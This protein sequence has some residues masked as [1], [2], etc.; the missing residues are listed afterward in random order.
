MAELRNHLTEDLNL[1]ADLAKSLLAKGTP[2]TCKE[3]ANVLQPGQ[4]NDRVFFL[5]EGIV[6]EYEET[7]TTIWFLGERNWFYN[8]ES[9]ANGTAS[10]AYLQALTV[11]KGISF[12]KKDIDDLVAE[13]PALEKFEKELYQKYLFR[14]NRL[15]RLMRV[16]KAM[17]RWELFEKQQPELKNRI[18]LSMVAS[19]LNITPQRFSQLR[20]ER[21]GK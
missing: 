12:L 2:F 9:Y 1:P 16:D 11:A 6:R 13:N 21:R 15:Y 10:T 3:N 14:M 8:V 7:E 20:K 18:P 5:Q 19:F 4:I 17:K